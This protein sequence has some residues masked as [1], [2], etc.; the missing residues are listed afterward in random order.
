MQPDPAAEVARLTTRWD[1][2][3]ARLVRAGLVGPD[4]IV[5]CEIWSHGGAVVVTDV[6]GDETAYAME[7][8]GRLFRFTCSGWE[9][10]DEEWCT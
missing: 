3:C 4:D 7:P 6:L 5:V 9:P 1:A 10:V 2:L 8:T